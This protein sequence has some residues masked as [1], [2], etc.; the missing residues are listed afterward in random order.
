MLQRAKRQILASA[1]LCFAL[2]TPTLAQD[3]PYPGLAPLFAG[4]SVLEI[5]IDAPLTAL[6]DVRPDKAYLDGSFT[7]TDVDG[8]QRK[9][10]LKLRTRGN[11]RRAKEHCDFAPIRLNFA[12]SEVAGTL[13]EG[14]DKLKLVTHCQNN[15]PDYENLLMREYLAYRM[16]HALT[17]KSFAVRLMRISYLNTENRKTRRRYGFVI[18]D[19]DAVAKRNGMKIAN[20]GLITSQYLE[21]EHASLI[22]VF[23]YM[24]GNTEYSVLRPEP[25][26]DCCHNADLMAPK[27][28]SLYTPLAY[29]FDFSGLVNAPYAE[30]N[31]RY[32]LPNVRT[33]LFRGSCEYDEQLEATLQYFKE[34]KDVLYAVIDDTEPLTRLTRASARRYLDSFYERIET[35]ADVKKWLIGKCYKT[36]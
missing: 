20:V 18:E 25:D 17:P 33:R 30:P 26:K 11:Y 2:L 5:T 4:D 22:H 23:Q 8:T 24:I 6:M 34:N 19:E 27:G 12:K 7:F 28:Q 3:D 9:V 35:P 32:K 16:L 15:E 36:Q 13:F 10:G 21:P 14:Q 29:D 31:P 1:L